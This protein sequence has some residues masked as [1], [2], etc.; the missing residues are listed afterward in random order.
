MIA[1]PIR[2]FFMRFGGRVNS[3]R[4]GASGVCCCCRFIAG[5][6]VSYRF[7]SIISLTRAG[8][9][10]SLRPGRSVV[11]LTSSLLYGLSGPSLPNSAGRCLP[12][13]LGNEAGRAGY[14]DWRVLPRLLLL[15]FPN[16]HHRRPP[17]GRYRKNKIVSEAAKRLVERNEG[18]SVNSTDTIG[19]KKP[20]TIEPK[21]SI[22]GFW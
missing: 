16:Q 14:P 7:N 9:C 4:P 22:G 15:H 8:R 19:Q 13:L 3:I 21:K 5:T 10:G 11:Q 12:F 2:N 20:E 1:R 17:L 18:Q 6:P